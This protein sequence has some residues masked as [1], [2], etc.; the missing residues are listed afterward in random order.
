MQCSTIVLVAISTL[1]LGG[2]LAY[3]QA[4]T[5][6]TFNEPNEVKFPPKHT[7]TH[8]I[9][10]PNE[11]GAPR[12]HTVTHTVDKPYEPELPLTQYNGHESSNCQ[13]LNGNHVCS[14]TCGGF[15]HVNFES[16][17]APKFHKLCRQARQNKLGAE[18]S[19]QESEQETEGLKVSDPANYKHDMCLFRT[20]HMVG[21]DK[22]R[23]YTIDV[24]C[25]LTWTRILPGA[26]DYCRDFCKKAF[27]ATSAKDE[28]ME[29]YSLDITSFNPKTKDCKCSYTHINREFA[30]L[31]PRRK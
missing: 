4:A 28:L 7:I 27:E 17:G 25:S 20:W 1:A 26:D 12:K 22:V 13:F 14:F 6:H 23:P 18:E 2:M 31:P 24:I 30:W 11:S 21:L 8:T 19:E 5:M 3:G 9:N 16:F 10:E 29:G 15:S